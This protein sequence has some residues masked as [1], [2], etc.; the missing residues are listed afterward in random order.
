MTK[1]QA[2]ELGKSI[3]VVIAYGF[4]GCIIGFF[5]VM[6]LLFIW[7]V[8]TLFA[9]NISYSLETYTASLF[10]FFFVKCCGIAQLIALK[11]LGRTRPSP[12]GCK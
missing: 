10:L 4:I 2:K 8:N 3:G 6:P 5:A 9:L 1:D 11:K 7:T 12:C